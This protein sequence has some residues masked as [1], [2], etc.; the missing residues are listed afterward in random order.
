MCTWQNTMQVQNHNNVIKSHMSKNVADN[1]VAFIE[2][3]YLI[4]GSSK[5]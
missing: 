3:M 1:K 5:L 4:V 2:Y